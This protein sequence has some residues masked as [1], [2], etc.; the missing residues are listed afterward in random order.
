MVII[1]QYIVLLLPRVGRTI[2][3]NAWRRSSGGMQSLP[4]TYHVLRI[5]LHRLLSPYFMEASG[6]ITLHVSP[7]VATFISGPRI[8]AT[9]GDGGST[10]KHFAVRKSH[11]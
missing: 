1:I 5:W 6:Y 11:T 7:Q 3:Y 8:L 10:I 9:L 4:N 2:H